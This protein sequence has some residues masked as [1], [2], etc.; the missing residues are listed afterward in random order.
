MPRKPATKTHKWRRKGRGLVD[1]TVPDAPPF[2]PSFVSDEAMNLPDLES[3]PREYREIPE[4][5]GPVRGVVQA[6]RERCLVRGEKPGY[7]NPL[8][9]L[10]LERLRVVIQLL[11]GARK[12]PREIALDIL[13]YWKW[14]RAI[15]QIRMAQVLGEFAELIHNFFPDALERGISQLGLLIDEREPRGKTLDALKWKA[16][17]VSDLA[18]QLTYWDAWSRRMDRPNGVVIKLAEIL[19]KQ[20]RDHAELE[21]TLEENAQK[22]KLNAIKLKMQQIEFEEAMRLERDR[23]EQEGN[24][25][26]IDGQVVPK[27]ASFT[28]RL[29]SQLSEIGGND[30]MADAIP[31]IRSGLKQL[32]VVPHVGTL[33]E[34]RTRMGDVGNNRVV[35][36]EKPGNDEEDGDEN[37]DE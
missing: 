13:K 7:V 18:E 15:S 23:L 9:E 22:S 34:R 12:A 21:I 24:K 3:V 37:I 27:K 6:I 35:N 4:L 25:V 36:T 10:P 26:A 31:S 29:S 19:G 2:S 33:A 16:T 1:Q 28:E 30:D 5:S 20:I 11:Q 8:A 17:L 14:S 32:A